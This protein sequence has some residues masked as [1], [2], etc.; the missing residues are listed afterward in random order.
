MQTAFR[1]LF[2]AKY[3]MLENIHDRLYTLVIEDLGE[4]GQRMSKAG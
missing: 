2:L 4:C 3:D 1:F